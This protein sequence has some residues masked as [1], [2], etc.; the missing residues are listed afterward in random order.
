[1]TIID[2]ET[3]MQMLYD[4]AQGMPYNPARWTTAR[5]FVPDFEV[6]KN[7]FVPDPVIETKKVFVRDTTF[8][9]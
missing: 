5:T 1:M 4:H 8:D 9:K 3:A 2:V 6:K 7:S